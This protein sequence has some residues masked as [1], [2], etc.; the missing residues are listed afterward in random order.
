MWLGPIQNKEFAE[1]VL[2]SIEGQEMEYKTW[3][4]I[5]G[6]VTMAKDVSCMDPYYSEV[7]QR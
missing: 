4:R 1:R 2:K 6:M 5:M 7:E 3:N